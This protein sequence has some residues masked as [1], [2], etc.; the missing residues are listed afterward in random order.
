MENRQRYVAVLLAALVGGCL[1]E[2]Q[3]DDDERDAAADGGLRDATAEAAVDG[4]SGDA[5]T[6]M[7]STVDSG[8]P[9]GSGECASSPHTGDRCSNGTFGTCVSDKDC[10]G[11]TLCSPQ[12]A[13]V[14]C[15]DDRDCMAPAGFC[16]AQH[17]CQS[18]PCRSNA[19]CNDERP[20]CDV[21]SGSC[22]GCTSDNECGTKT[23]DEVTGECGACIVGDDSRCANGL[24]CVDPPTADFSG[25]G[26]VG[27]CDGD[28]QRTAT[29]CQL[30]RV[31][32]Q[33]AEGYGCVMSQYK[34]RL[35]DPFCVA[36]KASVGGV[37]PA[38]TQATIK[39]KFDA[40][41]SLWS[42]DATGSTEFC[43]PNPEYATCHGVRSFGDVCTPQQEQI[44]CGA[45]I[46]DGTGGQV[47]SGICVGTPGQKL[48]TYACKVPGDCVGTTC[49]GVSPRY[50]NPF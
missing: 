14:L 11:N 3:R 47:A 33:C 27:T 24:T 29:A 35:G 10:S 41:K 21:A 2:K 45:L 25:L 31:D 43:I 18:A 5:T 23:C 7:D 8:G 39:A 4:S 1:T 9:D 6:K 42:E 17:Q 20:H 46:P 28:K 16:G 22:G 26:G 37:C 19:D 32:G 48:C 30:C 44:G 38:G 12:G 40:R 50:C 36:K 49:V 15:R 13:C 34:G